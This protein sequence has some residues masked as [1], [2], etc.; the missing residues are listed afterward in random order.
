MASTS[1]EYNRFYQTPDILHY[2]MQNSI[3]NLLEVDCVKCK[4]VKTR[5]ITCRDCTCRKK[6]CLRASETR[7]N[8]CIFHTTEYI[9]EHQVCVQIRKQV[10]KIN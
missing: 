2:D 3:M 6:G 9:H 7:F 1:G 10:R 4:R 5:N 8:R